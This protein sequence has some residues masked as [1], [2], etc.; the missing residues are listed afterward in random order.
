MSFLHINDITQALWNC[1]KYLYADKKNIFYQH[2]KVLN[3]EFENACDSFVNNKLSIHFGEGETK[4][5]FLQQGKNLLK[6]GITSNNKKIKQRH[7][8][9]Y[10]DSCL[11][12]VNIELQFL[13]RQANFLNPKLYRFLSNSLYQPCFLT[14]LLCFGTLSLD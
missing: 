11:K 13:Y 3:K 6:I 9:E 2:K 5:T 1:L 7:I 12:K 8:I 14:L 10:L 4:C